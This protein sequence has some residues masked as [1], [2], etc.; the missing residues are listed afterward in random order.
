SLI[1]LSGAEALMARVSPLGALWVDAFLWVMIHPTKATAKTTT[2]ATSPA[3]IILL[4]RRSAALMSYFLGLFA[5]RSD[6]RRRGPGPSDVAEMRPQRRGDLSHRD[7]TAATQRR[8]VDESV[9]QRRHAPTVD[10]HP[11]FSH[12]RR[13]RLAFVAQWVEAGRDDDGRRQ[14]RQVLGE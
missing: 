12:P 6:Y 1:S 5:T 4:R 13:V 11:R 3:W 7:G 10:R 9:D 8:E 2:I 14:P